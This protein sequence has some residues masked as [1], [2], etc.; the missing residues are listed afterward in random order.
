M[1]FPVVLNFLLGIF[2]TLVSFLLVSYAILLA[3]YWMSCLSRSGVVIWKLVLVF[4]CFV[5]ET[6]RFSI[7]FWQ[8]LSR[9]VEVINVFPW[10]WTCFWHI[11]CVTLLRNNRV[12]KN[13]ELP[14]EPN[15]YLGKWVDLFPVHLFSVTVSQLSRNIYRYS[16]GKKFLLIPLP[17]LPS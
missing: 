4:R 15:V 17:H 14:V 11:G 10:L 16:G 8:P 12:F 9:S 13:P 7:D 1:C 6:D 5:D 3:I 2:L